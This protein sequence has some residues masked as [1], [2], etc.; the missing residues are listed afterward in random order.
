MKLW[1]LLSNPGGKKED[2]EI[3]SG[4]NPTNKKV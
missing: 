4:N 3:K 2:T 1:I